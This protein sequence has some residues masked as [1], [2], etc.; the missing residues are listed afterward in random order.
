MQSQFIAGALSAGLALATV[1]GTSAQ[2]M[3]NVLSSTYFRVEAGYALGADADVREN[4]PGLI[5]GNPACNTTGSLND[6]GNSYVLG[7][8]IGYRVHPKIRTELAVGYR[9]GFQLD[10]ADAHVPPTSFKGD[11][12]S[13]TLMLNGYYDFG[14]AGPW[15]PFLSAGLGYARNELRTVSATN[16]GAGT[17]NLANFSLAGDTESGFAWSVGAGASYSYGN[18]VTLEVAY[19]YVDLGNI[20]IPA[21]TVSLPGFGAQSYGGAK[22]D[23]SSH[24]FLVG[25]RF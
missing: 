10:D 2:V 18:K 6:V 24:E 20:R 14:A 23:L 3:S 4:G 17:G 15:K 25:L 12:R 22:G 16:A 5:C 1:E 8:A 7:A 19:R 21:Q 13:W 11:I 9:G